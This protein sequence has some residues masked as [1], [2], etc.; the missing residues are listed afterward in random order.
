MKTFLDQLD[1]NEKIQ[2][3]LEIE[4]VLENGFPCV[5]IE[6]N[7]KFYLKENNLKTKFKLN[8]K[9]ELMENIDIKI[10]LSNKNYN[11]Q[12]RTGVN[13]N[14]LNIDNFQLVPNYTQVA[15]YVNDHNNNNPT[16]YLGFNGVW[17]LKIQEPFYRWQH[18]VTGQGWLLDP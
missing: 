1:I 14:Y 12:G 4:P 11:L 17:H 2:I 5:S 10:C 9:I 13:I 15:E 3:S 6:L 18:K 16:N 8:E 7:G